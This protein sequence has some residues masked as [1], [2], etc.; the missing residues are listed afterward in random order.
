MRRVPICCALVALL[1]ALAKV[2]YSHV[3]ARQKIR[4]VQLAE[5][6]WVSAE[7]LW[8]AAMSSADRDGLREALRGFEVALAGTAPPPA[9]A[10]LADR[11]AAWLGGPLRLRCLHRVAAGRELLRDSLAAVVSG[12]AAL[13]REGYCEAAL[14]DASGEGRA[15]QAGLRAQHT[16]CLAPIARGLVMFAADEAEAQESFARVTALRHADGSSAVLSSKDQ[17]TA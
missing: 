10:P 3:D 12:H 2:R 16:A 11:F 14:A 13:L 17:K 4:V 1:A 8:A 6:R 5:A 9:A 15:S 7:E